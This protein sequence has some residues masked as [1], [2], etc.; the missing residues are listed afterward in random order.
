MMRKT[1]FTVVLGGALAVAAGCT[2]TTTSLDR[3][4]EHY[5]A[6]QYSYAAAEFHQAV[7]ENP[8]WPPYNPGSRARDAPTR[9]RHR[10]LHRAS[11]STPTIP[12]SISP[13]Q[14]AGRGGQYGPATRTSRGP[15]SLSPPFARPFSPRHARALTAARAVHAGMAA[16]DRLEGARGRARRCAAGG[17]ERQGRVDQ[18]RRYAAAVPG[19]GAPRPCRARH[20]R[21]APPPRRRRIARARWRSGVT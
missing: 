11:R 20:E 3:G 5:R 14:R 4:I 7:S 15:S 21:P 9:R 18:P 10:R 12:R 16:R 17:L 6:G 2:T 19:Y 1:L 8:T 13:W